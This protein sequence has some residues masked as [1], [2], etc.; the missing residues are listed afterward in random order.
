MQSFAEVLQR[1]LVQQEQVLAIL[2]GFMAT[3]VSLHHVASQ[4]WN[5]VEINLNSYTFHNF[6]VMSNLCPDLLASSSSLCSLCR[7][8]AQ[9]SCAVAQAAASERGHWSMPSCHSGLDVLLLQEVAPS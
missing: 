4:M 1:Q 2:Q 3:H 9:V 7:K 5:R 8:V 6:V